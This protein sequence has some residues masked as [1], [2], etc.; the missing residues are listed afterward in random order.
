MSQRRRAAPREW[1]WPPNYGISDQDQVIACAGRLSPEKGTQ[2]FLQAACEIAQA[3]PRARFLIFGDGPLRTAL[4]QAS[5]SMP[6]ADRVTFAGLVEDFP[7][8]LPG[9]DLFINPSLAEQAPNVVLEAMTARVPCVAT[10]V[11]GVPEISGEI[12]TMLLVPP[13]NASA[14]AIAARQLLL[15]PDLAKR[16]ASRAYERVTKEYSASRQ[17]Q[18]LEN[19]FSEFRADT[20]P[21]ANPAPRT[22]QTPADIPFLSIVMPVRNEE[23]CIETILDSLLQQDYD[24]TRFGILVCDGLSD[25]RTPQIVAR[26]ETETGGR[27]R[28]VANPGRLSSAGRNCGVRA[29]RGDIVIFVDGHCTIPSRSMLSNV[30]GIYSTTIADVICRPQPLSANLTSPVQKA[31]CMARASAIGHGRDSTI[32][33]LTQR[34]Y[35]APDSSGAIY[36][37][38]VFDRIGFYDESFDACEDVE[39]NVRCREAGILAYTSPSVLVEYEARRTLAGLWKQMMRYGRGRARLYHKHPGAVSIA[40]L[41]P[42]LF[43]VLLVASLIFS[44]VSPYSLELASLL[45]VSYATAVALSSVPAALKHGPKI[46]VLTA[47]SFVCIHFGLGSG[48]LREVVIPHRSVAAAAR[49]SATKETSA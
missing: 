16:T 1:L 36:R 45:I 8:L 14:L 21:L 30:A 4:Q 33:S 19:L 7:A 17:H 46:G 40:A 37:R 5:A 49:T 38:E 39:F 20:R 12:A 25:D 11:G 10:A 27:V 41:A 32:F 15:D 6:I 48:F 47:L 28:F 22:S 2:Y 3:V 44:A 13:G 34:A 31:I 9:V 43:I 35:V 29:S 23:A 18:D 26:Y 24:P 42:A